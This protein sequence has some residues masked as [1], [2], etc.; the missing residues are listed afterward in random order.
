MGVGEYCK[1]FGTDESTILGTWLGV[2]MHAKLKNHSWWPILDNLLLLHSTGEK[3]L[4]SWMVYSTLETHGRRNF[5]CGL[6]AESTTENMIGFN[7]WWSLNP[8]VADHEKPKLHVSC[9]EKWKTLA[10][11]FY[12]EQNKKCSPPTEKEKTKNRRHL[13]Y[14]EPE[15]SLDS[16]ERLNV[17]TLESFPTVDKKNFSSGAEASHSMQ[18]HVRPYY[19]ENYKG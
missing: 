13:Q 6:F 14:Q 3:Q 8:K 4:Y 10:A 19:Q 11:D 18:E 2:T 5:C 16:L 1:T 17:R 7:K 15:T 12:Q 9:Q